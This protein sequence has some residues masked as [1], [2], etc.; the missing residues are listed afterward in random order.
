MMKKTRKSNLTKRKNHNKK[1][2]AASNEKPAGVSRRDF[3]GTARNW[4]IGLAVVG[5][6]IFFV[7]RSVSKTIQEHDLSRVENGRPTIVQIHD[8]QCSKCLALQRETRNALKDIDDDALDYV[9]ANIKTP[10]GRSFAARYGEQHV[11]LLLFDA[12]GRLQTVLRGQRRQQELG[13]A[14]RRLASN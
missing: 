12:E 1:V 13:P 2:G 4:T 10:E 11:T 5:G 8:P 7:G 3:F 6:G 14:F 9:I